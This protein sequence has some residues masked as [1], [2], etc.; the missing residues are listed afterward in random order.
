MVIVA[1]MIV[2][3]IFCC[4]DEIHKTYIAGVVTLLKNIAV[5]TV[6]TV[7]VAMITCMYCNY[8][9]YGNLL[10]TMTMVI[11]VITCQLPDIHIGILLLGHIRS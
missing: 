5:V 6:T 4:Y 2:T 7:I 8:C 11:V 9:C 10:V 3:R 1:M